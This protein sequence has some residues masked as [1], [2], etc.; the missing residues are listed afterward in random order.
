HLAQGGVAGDAGGVDQHVETAV[1]GLEFAHQRAAGLEIGHVQG[2]EAH[3]QAFDLAL[4][5]VDPRRIAAKVGGHHAAAG[6]R[7]RYADGGAE[8]ADAA[9]D[10]GSS[11]VHWVS[12]DGNRKAGA[13]KRPRRESRAAVAQRPRL[14]GGRRSGSG[15]WPTLPVRFFCSSFHISM[16]RSVSWFI[17]AHGVCPSMPPICWRNCC[18]WSRKTCIERSR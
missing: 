4:E 5:S 16:L 14:S 18:C 8:P 2:R 7:E 17:I 15:F 1:R 12:W 13:A 9:G 10:D 6:A 3:V 11:L